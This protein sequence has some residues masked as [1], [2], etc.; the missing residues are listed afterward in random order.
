M[1]FKKVNVPLLGVIE[2][3]SFSSAGI[4]ENEPKSSRLPAA[5]AR[6]K[7]RD[8]LPGSHPLGPGDP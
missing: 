4:A 5:S 2:N 3:M 8:S 7:I 1:M 6:R